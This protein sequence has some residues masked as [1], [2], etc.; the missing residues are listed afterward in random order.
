LRG[1]GGGTGAH[2]WGNLIVLWPFP[3][4]CSRSRPHARAQNAKRFRKSSWKP[5]Y[6]VQKAEE[7]EDTAF[8]ATIYVATDASGEAIEADAK[9]EP[10]LAA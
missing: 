5:S 10:A 7:K 6:K 1:S 2:T 3:H 9:P 4:P 8:I